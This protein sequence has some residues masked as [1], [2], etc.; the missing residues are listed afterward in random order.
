[1]SKPEYITVEITGMSCASCAQRIES[2][3]SNTEGVDESIVNFA[4][5]KV[6]VTGSIPAEEIHKIIEERRSGT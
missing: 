4:T 1:M 3:I 2:A 6:T 5:R